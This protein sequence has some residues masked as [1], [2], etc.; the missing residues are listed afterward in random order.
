MRFQWK[1]LERHLDEQLAKIISKID[2]AKLQKN[3]FQFNWKGFQLQV[4]IIK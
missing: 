3:E 4:S 1:H 2:D